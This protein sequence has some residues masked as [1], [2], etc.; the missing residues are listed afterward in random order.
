F[1]DLGV[2][3]NRHS[4]LVSYLEKLVWVLTGNLGQPGGQY[5]PATLIPI[6]RASKHE[7]DPR[8]APVSPVVG[9]R[10]LSGLIPCNVIPDEILTDHPRRYRALIVESGN[11]VHSL[12]DSQRMRE[13]LAA[14][15]TVVVIAVF[16]T[17]TARLADYVLP[18]ATQFEKHEATFFNF[19]FPNNVFHLRRPLLSPPDGPLP[20]PEI[21][22]RLVEAA[23]VFT[24]AEL[25]PLRAAARR[26]RRE[27]AAA[28][29]EATT[30]NPTLGSLAPVILYRTLGQT[31]PNR[32]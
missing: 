4:T 11:P 8:T 13:A 20:E 30:A 2:Q 14:L 31:L 1:E 12:A 24:D 25:E 27:F 10:I 5:A 7:L 22:A 3:M 26:G 23:G 18:A 17:E 32:A 6:V 16:M 28:F 15:D 21:H 9:A 19:E 29:A